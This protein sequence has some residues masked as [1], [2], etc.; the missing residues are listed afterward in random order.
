M[1]SRNV[2]GLAIRMF[3]P[4]K[5]TELAERLTL[6]RFLRFCIVKC[7]F[8]HGHIF[9]NL[10]PC[11]SEISNSAK[12][13][14]KIIVI[15]AH[16]AWWSWS[17]PSAAIWIWMRPH[18]WGRGCQ[19]FPIFPRFMSL[20]QSVLSHL[21]HFFNHLHWVWITTTLRTDWHFLGF[22]FLLLLLLLVL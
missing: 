5:W 4:Q 11:F 12:H 22:R 6:M 7:I 14:I 17:G 1:L 21:T 13:I 3:P 2:L 15:V 8:H 19:I 10:F 18:K 9:E 16:N 20:K